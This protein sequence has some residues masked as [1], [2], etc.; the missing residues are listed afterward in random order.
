MPPLQHSRLG[1]SIAHRW[2]NCPGSVRLAANRPDADD[3]YKREGRTAHLLAEGWLRTGALPLS[4]EGLMA[5]GVNDEMVE[6]VRTYVDHVRARVAHWRSSGGPVELHVE[7]RVTL[8]ELD[9]RKQ[10]T[11]D[12]E[13]FGTADAVIV[14]PAPN[15]LEVIDLKYG[16]GV[17]VEVQD[18]PQL[19][20]YALGAYLSLPALDRLNV[21][22]IFV[23][24]VQPRAEHR[25]GPVRTVEYR[26][27]DLR[28]FAGKFIAAALATLAPD[29]PL[30]PGKW[31]RFCPAHAECPA[32]RRHAMEVAQV[33]F[34]AVPVDLPPPPEYLPLP[35]IADILTKA[36]VLEQWLAA[37]RERIVR[38]LEQGKTVP[39]W[40]LVEKRAIRRWASESEVRA[41][42]ER[43]GLGADAFEPQTL[44]SPA[45]MEKVVGKK[46]LPGNL[47]EKKSSG[48]TLAPESDPRPG[49]A[50]GPAEDFPQLPAGS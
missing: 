23:T 40:K 11:G 8:A 45:Q 46:N 44:L 22:D 17:V 25:D 3:E 19:L 18:N 24:I 15:V 29:A 33:D 5:A 31:C 26:I 12:M 4:P 50:L 9:T 37:C 39:G 10:L 47:V 21:R 43:E 38:E 7:R 32:L 34:D 42:V 36:P 13:P 27:E 49:K 1:A 48:L 20:T 16:Q 6:H 41:W 2:M 28:A 14:A 30:N 35:V